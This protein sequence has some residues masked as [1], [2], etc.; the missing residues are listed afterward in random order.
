[1]VSA[2]SDDKS[3]KGIAHGINNVIQ[4]LFRLNLS[5]NQIKELEEIQRDP[6]D[7]FAEEEEEVDSENDEN[8]NNV[9]EEVERTIKTLINNSKKIVRYF[10]KSGLNNELKTKLRQEC[11]TRW[12]SYLTMLD[13]IIKN[14]KDIIKTL[15]ENKKTIY[16]DF[17]EKNY[18]EFTIICDFLQPLKEITETLSREDKPNIHLVLPS[19]ITLKNL[20]KIK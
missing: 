4:D 15:K 7:I 9:F 17:L 8:I 12:N 3:L 1:M 14:Y 19:I 10:K 18:S 11:P 20:L 5:K 13:S 2:F 16:I 6:D